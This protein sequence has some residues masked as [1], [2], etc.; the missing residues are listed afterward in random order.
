V[1]LGIARPFVGFVWGSADGD[2]TDHKLHGFASNP[3]GIAT[4]G[5]V[6]GLS[7][8]AHLDTSSAFA[9]RDYACPARSQGLANRLGTSRNIGTAVLGT[10]GGGGV[11]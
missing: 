10:F 2:P 7:W 1:D 5:L 9:G 4:S 8:F 3:I 11:E 6:T